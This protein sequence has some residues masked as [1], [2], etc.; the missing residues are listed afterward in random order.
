MPPPD[1]PLRP[2]G[3]SIPM[4]QTLTLSSPTENPT[5]DPTAPE[6]PLY[7]D[8]DNTEPCES[9]TFDDSNLVHIMDTHSPS[10]SINKPHIYHVSK[11]SS[12]HYGSL[13]DREANGGLAGS[14]VRILE[15]TGRT[16][17]VTGIDDHELP[18]LDIVTCAA[19][20][21]T[22]HGKVVLTMHEY[23]YYGRGN[24]IH[25]PGQIEG[26]QNTS[27]DKS[28]HVVGKQVITFLDGYSIISLHCR[29]GLMYMNL[30]GKPKNAD[31]NTY[32]HVLLTGPHEWDLLFWITP[33]LP[34]LVTPHG[35]QIPP[36]VLHMTP[37]EMNLAIVRGEF[38]I[39]SP[40][41]LPSPTLLSTN[42]LSQLNPLTLRS[43]GPISAGTTNTP[44]RK[45]STKPLNGLLLRLDIP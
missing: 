25:S 9:F 11:H 6:S 15:R 13:I 28:F 12:S 43:S 29:T 41:P 27:D 18:G 36:N 19:L 23:A 45:P 42:M 17:S 38:T 37:G 7:P 22:N 33:T 5:G 34:H 39:P 20:L 44:F 14:D 4:T 16:V 1:P 40:I 2:I 21:H 32:P 3:L 26:F 8:L 24:T 31:L 10:Y 35:L 30:I